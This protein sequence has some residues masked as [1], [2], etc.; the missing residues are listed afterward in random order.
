MKGDLAAKTLRFEFSEGGF[1]WLEGV[2]HRLRERSLKKADRLSL[3]RANI[4]THRLVAAHDQTQILLEV[5]ARHGIDG[6]AMDFAAGTSDRLANGTTQ[7]RRQHK[8]I[9]EAAGESPHA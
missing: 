3:V 7:E 1:C 5:R 6:H 8:S 4:E 9:R 2:N